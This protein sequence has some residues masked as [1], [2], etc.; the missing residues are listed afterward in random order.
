MSWEEERKKQAEGVAWIIK[1]VNYKRLND[2]EKGFIKSVR[3]QSQ[4]G[5][6]LSTSQMVIL[7]RIYREKG[8]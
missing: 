7:E 3:D 4:S 6:M 2:W 1:E 8:R 5:K